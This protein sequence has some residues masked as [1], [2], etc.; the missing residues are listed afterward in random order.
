MKKKHLEDELNDA[1]AQIKSLLDERKLDRISSFN[2][3]KETFRKS[4]IEISRLECEIVKL[5]KETIA[6]RNEY[7]DSKYF[8]SETRAYVVLA[9]QYSA[10]ACSGI[11]M[12]IKYLIEENIIKH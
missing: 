9:C 6:I 8:R 7:A 4:T 5:R 3:R 11:W 12:V 10:L 2:A 1:Y